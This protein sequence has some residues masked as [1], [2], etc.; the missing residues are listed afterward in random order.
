MNIFYFNRI[1]LRHFFVKMMLVTCTS[2][3][4]LTVHASWLKNPDLCEGN[5]ALLALVDRPSA[6]DSA[7]VVPYGKKVVEMGFEYQEILGSGHQLNL[8]QSTLR[9]GLPGLNEFVLIPPNYIHQTVHPHLGW[10][11]ATMGIKH[12]FLAGK[13]WILTVEGLI[14]PSSGSSD[15]GSGETGGAFN[16][17][18]T[19]S[20]TSAFGVTAMLGGTTESYPQDYG[21]Q[22]FRSVNPD[23]LI[24]W[25]KNKVQIYGEVYGQSHTGPSQGSGYNVDAGILYL[26]TQGLLLDVEAS[27]RLS[28][29]LGG[30]KRYG[31]AGITVM[32]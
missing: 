27:T 22:R 25:S 29:F 31:G 4:S 32:F 19:W 18:F 8:P 5:N 24:S 1:D 21:G 16:G 26:V 28:G 11:Q 6:A 30:F 13:N 17:I 23:I 9:I 2:F 15:F 10:S 7:C 20:V 12:G 14:T 3:G